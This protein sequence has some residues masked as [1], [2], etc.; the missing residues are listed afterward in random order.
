MQSRAEHSRRELAVGG[1][2]WG[3]GWEHRAVGPSLA[4]AVSGESIL[5][6]TQWITRGSDGSTCP[7]PCRT[8]QGGQNTPPLAGFSLADSRENSEEG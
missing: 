1:V 5:E 8:R 4:T 3:A 6:M 2:R 7:H